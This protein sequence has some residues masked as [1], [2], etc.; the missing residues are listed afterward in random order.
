LSE[1]VADLTRPNASLSASGHPLLERNPM[2]FWKGLALL[3]LM[4]VLVL[5]YQL[6]MVS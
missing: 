1:L 4:V 2:L 3:Q 6:F 5:V